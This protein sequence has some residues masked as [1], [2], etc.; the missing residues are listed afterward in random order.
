MLRY[1]HLR[2][3]QE[4]VEKVKK[5]FRVRTETEAMDKALENVILRD[6]EL[7]RRKRLMKRVLDLRKSL[8]KT[9]EDSAAW[10]RLARQE[11]DGL[12]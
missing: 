9:G 2:L 11:R 4:K 8:G 12:L 7:L 10:V 5:I 1:K 6:E 3:D